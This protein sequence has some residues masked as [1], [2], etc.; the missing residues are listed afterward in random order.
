VW[1]TD[2]PPPGFA[3]SGRFAQADALLKTRDFTGAYVQLQRL[4]RNLPANDTLRFMKGFC[5]LEMGEGVEALTYLEGLGSR[6]PAWKMQVEW[7]R[8]LGL[9]LSGD[10]RK[11]RAAFRDIGATP[12]HTYRQQGMKAAQLLE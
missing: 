12:G 4:E 1:H 10:T 6:Q 2:Y 5:M 8:A 3:V 7:Y 9:L 11:A